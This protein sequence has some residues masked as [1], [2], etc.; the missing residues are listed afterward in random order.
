MFESFGTKID[1]KMRSFKKLT[2]IFYDTK[3]MKEKTKKK[4]FIFYD[5]NV[6]DTNFFFCIFGMKNQHKK[7]EPHQQQKRRKKKGINFIIFC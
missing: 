2:S 5:L 4:F 6:L 1:L 3:K 7:V